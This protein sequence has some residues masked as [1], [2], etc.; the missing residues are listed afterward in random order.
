MNLFDQQF[1]LK[2]NRLIILVE[3]DIELFIFDTF[4][5]RFWSLAEQFVS[6][7]PVLHGVSAAVL[8]AKWCFWP[9]G[10]GCVDT[11]GSDLLFG[12]RFLR[13]SSAFLGVFHVS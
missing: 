11:I 7:Y 5:F 6:K 10:T 13:C 9:G 12:G 8:L 4:G 3:L 1:L 2:A